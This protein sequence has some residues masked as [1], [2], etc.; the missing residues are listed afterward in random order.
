MPEWVLKKINKGRFCPEVRPLS[1]LYTIF[2]RKGTP[3]VY[4]PLTNGTPFLYLPNKESSCH[5]HAGFNKLKKCSHRYVCSKYFKWQISLP[6]HVLRLVK[7]LPFHIPEAWKRYPF[8]ADPPCIVLYRDY[9]PSPG[10][11]VSVRGEFS[12]D[13]FHC[14]RW[15][16]QW[17]FIGWR[18][19][20]FFMI[21][22]TWII[23]LC[24]LMMF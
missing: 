22:I 4:L 7:F 6:F 13:T 18:K 16:K 2:G 1:F 23:H 9:P 17:L 3:F 10:I 21:K 19:I 15:P 11:A 20:N 14:S 5:F 8:R 24:H 12:I